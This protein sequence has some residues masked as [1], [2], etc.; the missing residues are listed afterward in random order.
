MS[1]NLPEQMHAPSSTAVATRP[2][3]SNSNHELDANDV[4]LPRLKIAQLSSKA[5]E[6][7][8]VTYGDVFVTYG[9]DDMEPTVI[10][11]AP[12]AKGELGPE[13]LFYVLGLTKGYSFTDPNG[14]L[15][16]TRD[17]SYPNLSLV[18]GQDPRNVRRTYDYTLVLPGS[19]EDL[20]VKFIMHGSWGGQAAKSMNTRLSLAQNRGQKWEETPFRLQVKKTENDKG[21]YS[22]AIIAPAQV[23]AKDEKAHAD[24]VEQFIGMATAQAVEDE[25]APAATPVD[26]PS[27]D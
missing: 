16:R 5:V 8:V 23:T 10:A 6:A 7:G 24:L 2:A 22:Q 27:L 13:V 15:D 20:P 4:R 12:K 9:E 14:R 17:G 11:K 19:F 18:K 1:D 25:P 21:A 26:A 3:Q